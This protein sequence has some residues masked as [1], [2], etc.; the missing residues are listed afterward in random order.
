MPRTTRANRGSK[1]TS[2]QQAKYLSDPLVLRR[3]EIIPGV[4]DD[5]PNSG[6]IFCHVPI[7]G[8]WLA[9]DSSTL[10]WYGFGWGSAAFDKGG[11]TNT[12]CR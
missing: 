6:R 8:G 12:C 1:E 3:G 2:K 5:V 11:S 10:P 9:V 7:V 4:R